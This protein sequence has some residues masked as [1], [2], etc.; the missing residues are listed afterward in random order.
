MRCGDKVFST[1]TELVGVDAAKD[2]ISGGESRRRSALNHA[3][4][5]IH[6]RDG[7]GADQRA[8]WQAEFRNFV[9][10][11]VE[12]DGDDADE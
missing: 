9:I 6:T 3:S 1:R 11:G 8:R 2:N 12:R 4:A 7:G 5:E 10:G